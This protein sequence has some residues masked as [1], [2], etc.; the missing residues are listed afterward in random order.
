MKIESKYEDRQ[1][2]LSQI[3]DFKIDRTYQDGQ[4]ISRQIVDSI[5]D[6]QIYIIKDVRGITRKKCWK[7]SFVDKYRIE[8]IKAN[9]YLLFD[10]LILQ[11]IERVSRKYP[12]F[13]G[14]VIALNKEGEVGAACSGIGKLYLIVIDIFRIFVAYLSSRLA[15]LQCKISRKINSNYK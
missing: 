7:D 9:I 12:D 13:M 14:A 11:A 6:R 5:Q 10:E 15:Y 2:I 4:Q 1:Q 3:V 8:R